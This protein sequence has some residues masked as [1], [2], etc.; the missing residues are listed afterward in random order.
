MKLNQ[1][2][3]EYY[4]FKSVSLKKSSQLI[5]KYI[6]RS[7]KKTLDELSIT[8]VKKINLKTGHSIIHHIRLTNNHKNDM[9]NR[10]ISFLKQV[11][12]HYDIVT[13]FYKFKPLKKDTTSF[14]RFYHDDLKLIISYLLHLNCSQNSIVYKTIVFLLLDSGVR[15]GELF[16]IKRKNID[17]S[18]NPYQIL[19]TTTK[20]NKNR[21]IPFSDFSRP[22]IEE[23]LSK[24]QCEYLFFNIIK[25]RQV[26]RNDVK[27]FYRRLKQ[28]LDIDR[29]HSHRFKKTFASLLV[30]NGMPIEHL[31]CLF[32][33]SR[34]STTML[35]V[36][37]KQ[38]K[39]LESYSKFNDWNLQ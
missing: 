16:Q 13:D 6:I 31:Q 22:Y 3:D 12:H 38:T 19:L 27:L 2:I 17:F 20:N 9:I 24:H 34:I 28:K 7:L 1:M 30:E 18:S 5:H 4:I 14:Q 35:Y 37:Y 11:L 25:K 21:Y 10:I 15:I 33:H 26:N 29:I 36:Q 8:S 23:L 39:S 32:D